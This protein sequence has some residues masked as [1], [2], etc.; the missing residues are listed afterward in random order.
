MIIKI[1]AVK[2]YILIYLMMFFNGS[3]L[4][5]VL[6]KDMSLELSIITYLI[7]GCTIIAFFVKK[8]KFGNQYC[9]IITIVLLFSVIFVRYTVGGVGLLVLVDYL[10]CIMVAFL[11]VC[12]DKD[13]FATRM[14]NVVYYFAAISFICYIIQIISPNILQLILKPFQSTFAYNDWSAAEYGGGV[15]Q[16]SF[17]AWGKLFY[18]MREGEMARN[19]GIFTEPGNFQI[20]LNCAIFLLLFLPELYKYDEKQ[21]KRR[22][23]VIVT[24][25]L[26]CQ[27]TSG[28]LI[29]LVFIIA[30]FVSGNYYKDMSAVRR[31]IA[32]LIFIALGVL[33]M[34][35]NIRGN[36]SLLNT[37]LFSKLFDSGSIDLATSTGY[38]RLGSIG[39]A[40]LV[41]LRY[42]LGAG[43]DITLSTI[44]NQLAG[45]AGG[46]LMT[47]GAALGILPFIITIVWF[48]RP[49]IRDRRL[50][51]PAKIGFIIMFLQSCMA[52]SKVFYPYLV[53]IVILIVV[54][55]KK[56]KQIE[57]MA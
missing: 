7:I 28:Y 5:T 40:A 15:V 9:M 17:I 27:S 57:I 29:L 49:V 35:Y 10:T 11:A 20:V 23:V 16:R 36:E 42:P 8:K 45:S 4:Y 14:I 56:E 1:N 30:F 39:T 13:N 24:A 3:V 34:D 2:Q 50:N 54:T 44:Q 12:I 46:A 22:F 6:Q 33:V 31:I 21:L 47:Y 53:S 55:Y 32:I 52:Q 37:A 26:T 41:M 43:F 51:I 38:W 18:T 48:T 19:M 25:L